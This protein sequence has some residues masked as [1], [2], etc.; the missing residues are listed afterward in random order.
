M[1]K[2]IKKYKLKSIGTDELKGASFYHKSIYLGQSPEAVLIFISIHKR[3]NPD[4][5]LKWMLQNKKIRTVQSYQ[6]ALEKWDTIQP[7]SDKNYE[8]LL[9]TFDV[10]KLKLAA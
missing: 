5:T 6:L 10:K 2:I 4:V 9:D 1:E 3:L 7:M 8:R